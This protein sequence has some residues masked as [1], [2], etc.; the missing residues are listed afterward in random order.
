MP[1][2]EVKVI[3]GVFTHEEKRRIVE[4]LSE[5]LIE[6][7]GEQ[8]RP[9]TH[10]LITE[11]PSG[12]CGRSEAPPSTPRT[13]TP[14]GTLQPCPGRLRSTAARLGDVGFAPL[15]HRTTLRRT[16]QPWRR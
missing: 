10:T 15:L 2:V 8:M 11:T 9:V 5:T 3:E 7:T 16:G 1:V 4:R 14:C 12:E 6:L 13:S